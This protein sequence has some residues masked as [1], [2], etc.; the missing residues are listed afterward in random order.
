MQVQL[1]ILQNRLGGINQLAVILFYQK[2][3]LNKLKGK[4]L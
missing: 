1:Y 2:I 3:S 4:L